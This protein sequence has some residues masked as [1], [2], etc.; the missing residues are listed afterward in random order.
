MQLSVD[1]SVR[2]SLEM[3]CSRP[4]GERGAGSVTHAHNITAATSTSRLA[5]AA[6]RGFSYLN[7]CCCATTTTPSCV[8]VTRVLA[9][10]AGLVEVVE[11][12]ARGQVP[13]R[14]RRPP[15][16]GVQQQQRLVVALDAA[17]D[18]VL[19]LGADL[20]ETRRFL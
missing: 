14:H 1:E 7:V 8:V 4:G 18:H 16:V 5:S 10:V 11:V 9:V 13:R 15:R 17:R 3:D 20:R 2:A 19:P 12:K 6:A